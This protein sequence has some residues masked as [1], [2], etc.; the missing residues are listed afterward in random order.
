[1]NKCCP[2]VCPIC[3]TILVLLLSINVNF[4]QTS[5]EG[6]IPSV[7]EVVQFEGKECNKAKT[8]ATAQ[9][10]STK[11]T[12]KNCDP[13]NC[14]VTKCVKKPCKPSDCTKKC[15][16]KTAKATT[17]KATLVNQK[18]TSK[19]AN[20]SAKCTKTC[21]KKKGSVALKN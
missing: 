14:D 17:T 21:K 2:D 1:M 11:Q 12:K 5:N 8:T 16:T 20:C 4:A 9:T 10:V 18:T 19:K 13:T 7:S 15:T 6:W 3:T